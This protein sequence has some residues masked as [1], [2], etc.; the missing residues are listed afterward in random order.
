[1]GGI[2]NHKLTVNAGLFSTAAENLTSDEGDIWYN[3]AEGRVKLSLDGVNGIV[4]P[5]GTH[6]LVYGISNGW[7]PLQ[8]GGG[9]HQALTVT[10]NRA[11]AFPLNPGRKCTLA[12][13]A[14]YI[15][16]AGTGNAR[17]MLYGSDRTTGLPGALLADYSTVSVATAPGATISGW[18]VST[19]LKPSRYWVVFVPQ[20]SA[21]PIMS[22]YTTYNPV[23]PWVIAT[24]TF[25]STTWINCV[26]SDTGF[27]GAPPDPFGAIAG[28]TFGPFIYAKLTQ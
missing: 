13:F 20:T 17:V 1:M 23:V 24:P 22:G 10:N 18:T 8:A 21:A 11:Y 6:P 2:A 5:H 9:F 19:A 4:G 15:G 27:S 28:S 25:A 14:A 3:S 12:G 7:Y 16:T 26:Y